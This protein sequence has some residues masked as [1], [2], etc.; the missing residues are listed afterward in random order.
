MLLLIKQ[1]VCILKTIKSQQITYQQ[2]I[3]LLIIQ[4][5]LGV[6]K[7]LPIVMNLVQYRASM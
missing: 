6:I 1:F 3:E 7:K 2:A 5:D 4:S